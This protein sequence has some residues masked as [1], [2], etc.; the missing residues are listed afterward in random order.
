MPHR[1]VT[2]NLGRNASLRKATV[3]SLAQALLWHE[4]ITTTLARAK[5]A[6]RLTERL[7]TLGKSGSLAARRQAASLL[8]DPALVGRLFTEVAPRFS[9]RPGGYTR[10]LHTGSRTG[11]G[12]ATAVLEL[13]ERAAQTKEKPKAKQPVALQPMPPAPPVE[14]LRPAEKKVEK[15]EREPEKPKGFVDGL[16]K[17][18][19]KD[20]PK[21]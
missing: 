3:R 6:Q 8:V 13:V 19:K 12:A 4:Q 20:R 18:F 17:F 7:I 14:K 16:R 11:D 10:I 21:Q 15:P 1:A 2:R 5:E 9:N